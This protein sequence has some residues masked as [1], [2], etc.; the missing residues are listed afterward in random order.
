VWSQL[1]SRGKAHI[2]GA[3][4]LSWDVKRDPP[5]AAILRAIIHDGQR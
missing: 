1:P 2:R 3:G 4:D 5:A